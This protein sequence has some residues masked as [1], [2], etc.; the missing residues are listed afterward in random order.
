MGTMVDT[1][2][3]FWLYFSLFL[4]LLANCE[5]D[6]APVDPFAVVLTRLGVLTLNVVAILLLIM[7]TYPVRL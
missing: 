4:D 6:V 1:F 5:L 7:S 3:S 2:V